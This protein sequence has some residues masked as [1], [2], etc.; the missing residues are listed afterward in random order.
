MRIDGTVSSSKRGDHISDFDTD[1]NVRAFL[2]SSKAGGVGINLVG[3]R[4][5]WRSIVLFF[6]LTNSHV[7]SLQVAANRVV[8][9]DAHFN[10]A[11]SEQAIF[12]CYRYGQTKPVFVYRLLT[13]ASMEEKVYARTVTKSEFTNTGKRKASF[14]FRTSHITYC[15]DS[16]SR[17]VCH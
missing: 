7:P 10:P 8:L 4:R 12:R 15:S 1:D 14:V 17:Q 3:I 16:W 2:L 9:M 13:E 6:Y 11:V 5:A